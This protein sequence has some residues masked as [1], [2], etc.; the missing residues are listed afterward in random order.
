MHISDEF[1]KDGVGPLLSNIKN[2]GLRNSGPMKL[3]PRLR[4]DNRKEYKIYMVR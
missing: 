2:V 3:R 1:K 4:L